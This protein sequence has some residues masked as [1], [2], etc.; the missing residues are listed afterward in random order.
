MS[1]PDAIEAGAIAIFEE[2]YGDSVRVISFGD[3]STELC[4]GTHA[5]ATGEIGLIKI[6]SQ[7]GIAAGV[8]RIEALTGLG[9]L[10]HM[11]RQERALQRVANLLKAPVT[12]LPAR[13]EKLLEERRAAEQ[14][15]AALRA[16][17]RGVASA[18]LTE[19]AREVAGVRVVT[20]AVDGASDKELRAMV[21]DLRARLGTGV[22]LLAAT[23]EG[24]VS[25]ALGVTENLTKQLRAGDLVREVAAVV[26]GKGG[27]RP[28]FA[29]AGGAAPERLD[30]AFARLDALIAEA[31]G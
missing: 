18:D 20:A 8:R 11:R 13:V 24:R 30:E 29:R 28:E 2:K 26:G 31:R 16:A 19:R 21:D 27:G 12:E 9:A 22:V 3:F 23:A 1:Y 14:E 5:G 25:L 7:S 6:V 4:G 15:L 17:R 10:E